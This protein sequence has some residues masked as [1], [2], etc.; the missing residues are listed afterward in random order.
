[1]VGTTEHSPL[2][3]MLAAAAFSALSL[4]LP[5]ANPALA[6]TAAPE[7]AAGVCNSSIAPYRGSLHL[8][9]IQ[10]SPL[11][12]SV[13]EQGLTVLAARLAEKT[14]LEEGVKDKAIK[15]TGIDIESQDICFFPF[16]YW[17]V[18]GDFSPLSPQA[19]LKVS[20]Y[21]ARGGFIMFD[22]REAGLEW[23]E[24]L[25]TLLG[26]VNL[27]TLEAMKDSHT[28]RNT[29]YK[30]STLPGSINLG[31]VYVQTPLRAVGDRVSQVIVA[32][33]NWAAAWAGLTFAPGSPGQEQAL[34]G[35]TNIVL[36]AFTGEYKGDQADQTLR[37]LEP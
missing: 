16:I 9:Y 8:T 7:T 14:S 13:S 36:Y 35:G 30:N 10:S 3:G 24:T 28:L 31:P 19:Q 22:I 27:G 17:P 12:N 20:T 25:R 11:L 21:L 23:R 1:M 15:V 2:A 32:E 26:Q 29:F 5:A 37:K 34:R 33:R 18:G 6:Q 4:G